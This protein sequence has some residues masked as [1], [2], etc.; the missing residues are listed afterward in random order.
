MFPPTHSVSIWVIL[1]EQ[2]RE[3]AGKLPL[4]ARIWMAVPS[5]NLH[6]ATNQS[7]YRLCWETNDVKHLLKN[8]CAD[9]NKPSWQTSTGT[10]T[11]ITAVVGA[12]WV[13]T[14]FFLIVHKFFCETS[15]RR[16]VWDAQRGKATRADP[17]VIF[18]DSRDFVLWQVVYMCYFFKMSLSS[19]HVYII[20]ILYI[21]GE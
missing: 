10:D 11:P 2:Q 6:L 16:G 9:C 8:M 7:R 21:I 5:P 14:G 13:S 17:Q 12:L 15:S 3:A 19:T 4:A 20:Y 18:T 1:W